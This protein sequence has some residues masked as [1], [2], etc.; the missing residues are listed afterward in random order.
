[1]L[2]FNFQPYLIKLSLKSEVVHFFGRL[3][4]GR[5]DENKKRGKIQGCDHLY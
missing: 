4:K 2:S 5:N 1:M 3:P